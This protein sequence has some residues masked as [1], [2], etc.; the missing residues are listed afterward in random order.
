MMTF[1]YQR[2]FKSLNAA[3]FLP[4]AVFKSMADQLAAKAGPS[5]RLSWEAL[6]HAYHMLDERDLARAALDRIQI[7]ALNQASTEDL[8]K[9][10]DGTP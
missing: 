9:K 10:L 8:R 1:A 6:G 4:K 3:E 5:D 2:S 7:N